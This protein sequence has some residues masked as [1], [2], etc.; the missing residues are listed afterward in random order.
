MTYNPLVAAQKAQLIQYV[1]DM[2]A[3]APNSLT[4]AV[5]PRIAQSGYRFV[6]Y[7]IAKDFQDEKFYGYLAASVASPG[8]LVLAIRGTQTAQEWLLN[9]NALPL[10]YLGKGF[11]P[12]GF[13]SIAETFRLSDAL[14]T[15]AGTVTDALNAYNAGTPITSITV[16]GHSLGGALATLATAQIA[17][18]GTPNGAALS[19]W[20]YASPT[21]AFP[22]FAGAFNNAVPA[23]YRIW[24]SL[25]I[26]PQVPPFPYVHVGQNEELKQTPAQIQQLLVTPPCEHHL[27]T[28][29]W[30]LDSA[31]FPLDSGCALKAVEPMAARAH[32]QG[33]PIVADE[34]ALGAAALA[35][36]LQLK[37]AEAA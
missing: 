6:N 3:K 24:N 31:H 20:T 34:A 23:S 19:M 18:T 12:A 2:Y 14:G 9:F 28:Y 7:L 21:V 17:F 26:V 15:D 1:Y 10:P 13:R 36:A 25:D 33:G 5:D 37:M 8:D 29:E 30:L 22:D 4:P 35:N 32:I 27:T 16:L 11:V